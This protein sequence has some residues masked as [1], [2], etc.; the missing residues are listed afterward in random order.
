MMDQATGCGLKNSARWQPTP[1]HVA[2]NAHSWQIWL[3]EAT[4]KHT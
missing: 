2:V 3:H 1:A 4:N